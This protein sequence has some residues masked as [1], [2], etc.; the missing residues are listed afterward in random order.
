MS[1]I[2]W[3]LM[4]F[5]RYADFSGRSSRPEYWWFCL[6]W[7]AV[8]A[9]QQ[10]AERATGGGDVLV[11]ASGLIGL[12]LLIP[13]LAVGVRRLHDTDRSGWWLLLMLVPLVGPLVLLAFYALRGTPGRNRFGEEVTVDTGRVN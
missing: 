7:I 2:N 3:A 13:S 9:V 5:R 10:I 8:G 4:P 12:L 11:A 1:P 6:F